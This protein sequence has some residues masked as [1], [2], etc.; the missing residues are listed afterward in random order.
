[1]ANYLQP[2]AFPLRARSQKGVNKVALMIRMIYGAAILQIGFKLLKIYLFS[3]K[4]SSWWYATY[5]PCKLI[6]LL[7]PE[8]NGS[9]GSMPTHQFSV[10]LMSEPDIA[11]PAC[12][13]QP[14]RISDFLLKILFVPLC[15][16]PVLLAP[17]H[18]S[19]RALCRIL[20]RGQL[21]FQMLP[22]KSP[23]ISQPSEV[24]PFC[25]A[26]TLLL[27][28]VLLPLRLVPRPLCLPEESRVQ[29]FLPA[30]RLLSASLPPSLQHPPRLHPLRCSTAVPKLPFSSRSCKSLLPHVRTRGL[31]LHSV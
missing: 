17:K 26:F 20:K 12:P 3:N 18:A 23:S 29:R 25:R 9:V 24:P 2:S 1:M 30:P 28:F 31:N 4:K 27:S 14:G 19:S 5:I 7:M 11:P 22:L 15:L 16:L 21:A 13:T 8:I 10:M 6:M